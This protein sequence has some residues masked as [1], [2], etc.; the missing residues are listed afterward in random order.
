EPGGTTS[1]PI[2][3][4]FVGEALYFG[5]E[6]GPVLRYHRETESLGTPL[7][8]H[9]G[10]VC[11]LAR[12]PG[13]TEIASASLDGTLRLWDASTGRLRRTLGRAGTPLRDVAYAQDGEAL[14]TGD[15][16]GGVSIVR[17]RDGSEERRARP[18]GAAITRV[19]FSRDGRVVMSSSLDR[20]VRLETRDG[21][22]L[23]RTTQTHGATRALLSFDGQFLYYLD[24]PDLVRLAAEPSVRTDDPQIML[25]SAEE[26]AGAHLGDEGLEPR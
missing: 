2:G 19:R 22:R 14:V 9:T 25:R 10:A 3:A 18:H 1:C 20:S 17:R 8:G 7:E 15:A 13:G 23:V 26:R 5:T 24:G 21:S 6:E 11:S 12:A 4:R 16:L